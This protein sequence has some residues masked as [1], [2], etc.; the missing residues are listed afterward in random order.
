M[1]V[2]LTSALAEGVF[3]LQGKVMEHRLSRKSG[4]QFFAMILVG[5]L[6]FTQAVEAIPPS[7]ANP[8]SGVS[9]AGSEVPRKKVHFSAQALQ[10]IYLKGQLL[11]MQKATGS[12]KEATCLLSLWYAGDGSIQAV[13]LAKA[14]GFPLIDQAC[15]QAVI[16]RRLEGLADGESGGRTFFP[17][18]WVFGPKEGDV[19]QLP[20]IKLDPSIPQLPAAGAMHPL[21]NYPVDALAQHARGICR[22][23]ITVSAAGV[24]SSIEITQSTGSGALDEACKEA[25]SQ[26]AFVPATNGGQPVSGTTDVAVVWRL[27]RP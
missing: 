26:S 6:A 9:A 5:A 10:A 13:Q 23:R 24:V 20:Q 3:A 22:M 2:V 14:S 4:A 21:P 18:H 27:P 16:G 19:P 25:V 12:A 8:P 15:L 17:I 1:Q 11:W 7:D